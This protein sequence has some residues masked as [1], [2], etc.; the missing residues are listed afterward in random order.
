M[1]PLPSPTTSQNMRLRPIRPARPL[2]H[3]TGPSQNLLSPFLHCRSSSSSSKSSSSPPPPKTIFSGIQPTGIPHV[4]NYLGALRQW[5]KLQDEAEEGTKLLFS[6]VDL[7]AITVRQDRQQLRR[8]K[9]E[10][11]ATLLAV[12]LRPE[13]CV[14]F[15]QSEVSSLWG[16]RSVRWG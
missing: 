3:I 1:H 7:H 6:I 8:W 5:K 16:F 15:Y 12:G 2:H 11:L 9:R 4:G 13:K 14:M 10:G